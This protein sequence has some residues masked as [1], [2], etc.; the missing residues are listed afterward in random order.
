MDSFKSL[1]TNKYSLSEFAFNLLYSR[2]KEVKGKKG[3]FLI[4]E[5]QTHEFVYFIKEGALRS[6]YI[7]KD[8]K[9]VTLWFGF[10]GDIL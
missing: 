7:N 5:G 3:D 10:E 6:Y 8:G 9:D 4:K 2:M 1:F